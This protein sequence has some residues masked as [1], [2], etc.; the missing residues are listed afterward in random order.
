MIED[1]IKILRR[2]AQIS[3]KEKNEKVWCVIAGNDRLLDDIAYNAITSK[4]RAQIIFRETISVDSRYT[5]KMFDCIL[6]NGEALKISE[7]SNHT[8]EEGGASLEITSTYLKREPNL[9]VVVGTEDYMKKFVGKLNKNEIRIKI[10]LEDHTT[11][12]INAQLK[13]GISL[14]KFIKNT[15]NPILDTSEVVLSTLLISVEDEKNIDR[16]KEISQ[17][18][19]LFGI[20]LKSTIQDKEQNKTENKE[21]NKENKENKDKDNKEDSKEESDKENSKKEESEDNE[22]KKEKDKI[23]LI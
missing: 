3:S 1:R 11:G 2:A 8:R 9:L 23:T 16:I 12:F 14:P 6:L 7:L 18:N 5:A 20:D 13:S 4:D 10:I 21:E 17:E 19:N 22:E 15:V